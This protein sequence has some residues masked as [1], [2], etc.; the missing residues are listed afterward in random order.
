MHKSSLQKGNVHILLIAISILV[1]VAALGVT[2]WKNSQPSSTQP[3]AQVTP[4]ELSGVVTKKVTSCGVDTLREDGTIKKSA[5]IC[6]GGEYLVVN[7]K[8]IATSSGGPGVDGFSVNTDSIKPGDEVIVHYV[9][10]EA[11]G[12]TLDCQL[13]SVSVTKHIDRVESF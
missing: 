13:C 5:G 7:S 9:P 8:S 6:D 12:L 10:S 4:L 2:L 1:L 11:G 3:E